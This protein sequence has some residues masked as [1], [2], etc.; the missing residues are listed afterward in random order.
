MSRRRHR[1]AADGLASLVGLLATL[2]APLLAASF[3]TGAW[4]STTKSADKL[5]VVSKNFEESRLLAEI[6]ARVIE[7]RTELSVERRMNLAGTQLCLDALRTGAADLYPEYTGTGL[8]SILGLPSS[9]DRAGVL[10]TVRSE[11]AKQWDLVWLAPLGFENSF[12]LAVRDANSTERGLSTISG[13]VPLAGELTAGFGPEFIGRDDGYPGL[14]KLYGLRFKEAHSLQHALKY[15]A[16]GDGK[17]DVIDVYTTDGRIPKYHLRVLQDDRSFFPPYEAVPLVRGATL[18]AHPEVGAALDLLAGAIDEER[19][20]KW[21]YL[22]QEEGASVEQVAEQALT[23]LGLSEAESAPTAARRSQALLPYMWSER[24]NL[25]RR[26]AEH[27]GLVAASLL[28]SILVAV[29]LGLALENAR[30]VA[31]PII[32]VTG[33]LQTV[34]SIALL[35]FMIP[36]LGI[37]VPPAI[38]A[39]FLYGLFPIVRNTFTGVEQADPSAVD[40]AWAMGMTR[41]QILRQIRLP[42]A[43]P[44]VLA[45]IRTAAVI[46]VG[47]ATLAAFIGAGGLGE[48]IVAGLQMS[49][50]T[51]VLSGAIPA[52]L[53]ALIFD[54]LL[55]WIERAVRPRGL[56]AH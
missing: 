29:P 23:E 35:A 47:T 24:A 9:T 11:F 5:V 38:A 55:A 50:P 54:G 52:A 56:T 7:T 49:S 32:R 19:M 21:N 33:L 20:R 22:L 16:A 36:F 17:V 12:E 42:L 4:G 43:L 13:L 10:R 48:P 46:N 39:L 37:G 26:T 30:R 31:E 53:L 28:L 6:F 34:P 51:V 8:V 27:L 41:G 40:A 14:Q 2:F 44:I 45:G 18:R 1:S 15:E 25:L 3:A